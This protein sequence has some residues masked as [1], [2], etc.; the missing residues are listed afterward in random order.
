MGVL[1]SI[2]ESPDVE[3]NEFVFSAAIAAMERAGPHPDPSLALNLTLTLAR[4][5]TLTLT[6]SP[7]LEWLV[8]R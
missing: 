2:E 6:L 3:P 1:G 5:L 7:R 4:T 8:S